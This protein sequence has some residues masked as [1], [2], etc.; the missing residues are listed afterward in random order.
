MLRMVDYLSLSTDRVAGVRPIP[1]WHAE[2][3]ETGYPPLHSTCPKIMSPRSTSSTEQAMHFS[4]LL[5][6]TLLPGIVHAFSAGWTWFARSTRQHRQ[7]PSPGD[8]SFRRFDATTRSPTSA[9]PAAW[10]QQQQL[11]LMPN[12]YEAFF[13]KASKLGADATRNLAPE[14]RAQRAMEA[15]WRQRQHLSL[16]SRQTDQIKTGA[17]A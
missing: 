11:R 14:E 9:V 5:H 7:H 12:E 4:T 6:V 1:L 13:N 17:H 15:S 16:H 8:G 10:K 2:F 3:T